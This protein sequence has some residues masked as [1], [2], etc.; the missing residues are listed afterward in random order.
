MH[1]SNCINRFIAIIANWEV[2]LRCWI[3]SRLSSL[4]HFIHFFSLLSFPTLPFPTGIPPCLI[5]QS[6]VQILQ[7]CGCWISLL[8]GT[9]FLPH[10]LT[11]SGWLSCTWV[12]GSGH[13]PSHAMDWARTTRCENISLRM[14]C[15]VGFSVG[16]L[17]ASFT[18]W[19]I[20]QYGTARRTYWL[21]T[22]CTCICQ[23]WI[24]PWRILGIA[25]SFFSCIIG[26]TPWDVA[27]IIHLGTPLYNC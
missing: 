21:A 25:I 15:T 27:Y 9:S 23:I 8:P 4:V 10:S 2:K 24:H 6:W 22:P 12:F 5:L 19:M 14:Y 13:M 16:M 20:G 11:T 17:V 26:L 1:L 18:I 3:L 7:V